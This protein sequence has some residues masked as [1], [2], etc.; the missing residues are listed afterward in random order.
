VIPQ[1]PWN[2]LITVDDILELY[3]EGIRRYGG[4]FSQP[5]AGCVEGS[6]GAAYNAELYAQSE[7]SKCGLCFAGCLLFYLTQNHCFTDGNKR[8]GWMAAAEV[9]RRL[10][11]TI[12]ATDDEANLF[13]LKIACGEIGKAT[14]VPLWLAQRLEEY[15]EI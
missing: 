15:T 10:G 12:K 14:D 8:I 4:D 3:E 7:D 11:L 5:T 13:C 2:R 9:L 1:E 6:L